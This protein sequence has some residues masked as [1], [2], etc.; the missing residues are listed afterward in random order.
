MK[1]DIMKKASEEIACPK[2]EIPESIL[3]QAGFI[4]SG[5]AKFN[6]TL[7]DFC[8]MLYTKSI[9]FGNINA[10]NHTDREITKDHVVQASNYIF[11]NYNTKEK[12]KWAIAGQVA[13]YIFTATAGIGAGYISKSWGIITFGLSLTFTIVLIITRLLKNN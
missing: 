10:D 2:I 4:K 9:K 7:Q 3:A 12:S 1:I 11:Y 13:E 8:S 6:D 5:I